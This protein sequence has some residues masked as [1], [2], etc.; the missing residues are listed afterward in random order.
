MQIRFC[1][2]AD[3]HYDDYTPF[4]PASDMDAVRAMARYAAGFGG[5]VAGIYTD[6]GEHVRLVEHLRDEGE[7]QYLE[8]VLALA[9]A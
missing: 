9:T 6:A 5:Y 2:S 8:R 4:A 1:Y 3:G 7:A